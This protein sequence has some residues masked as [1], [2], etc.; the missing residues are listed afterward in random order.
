MATFQ[1]YQSKDMSNPYVW[2]GYVTIAN[3]NQITINDFHGNIGTYLG[4]FQYS[5]NALQGGVVTGYLQYRNYNVDYQMVNLSVPASTVYNLVQSGNALALEQLVLSGDD[6]INGSP[7]NDVLRGL[8]G[9]DLINGGGGSDTTYGGAGN[10]NFIYS[11]GQDTDYGE[12]GFDVV[13]FGYNRS[14]FTVS[15]LDSVTFKA[16]QNSSSDSVV[17]NTAERL[18]F[19]NH[20]NIALDV[21]IGQNAGEAYRMYQA[22]FNRTPD[23]TGL[24]GWI[25]Y[26]DGGADPLQMSQLFIDSQE[27]RQGYGQLDNT[28]FVQLLYNNVLHRN[29]EPTGVAGWVDGLNHGLTRA[30]VLLGFSE[31]S[32][33]VQNVAP[34][35]T[36][37]IQYT[38]WWLT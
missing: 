33:N 5:A 24:A 4:S 28:S 36:N 35:I 25:N 17:V 32:E 23:S 13:Q 29:G 38:E 16:Q 37:G 15:R 11:I 34:A 9:N 18:K 1:A 6:A 2:Y 20:E 19:L 26:L 7:Y 3:S 14:N 27:F 31:S 10:D 21:G 30:Q 12:S 8:Y 22:S